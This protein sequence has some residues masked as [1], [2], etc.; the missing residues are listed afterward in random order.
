MTVKYFQEMYY[1]F[2]TTRAGEPSR[3]GWGVPWFMSPDG[4]D[5]IGKPV[6]DYY[7]LEKHSY[8]STETITV[9]RDGDMIWGVG[10]VDWSGYSKDNPKSSIN[11]DTMQAARNAVSF[12][13][14]GYHKELWFLAQ[15]TW[16]FYKTYSP[17][18]GEQHFLSWAGSTE[19][20]VSKGTGPWYQAIHEMFE[21][22][23]KEGI[24]GEIY[25]EL[26]KA[27][28]HKDIF[29]DQAKSR[30]REVQWNVIY[31]K[32]PGVAGETAH[33]Q[34]RTL[35]NNRNT[36]FFGLRGSRS[37][38]PDRIGEE[39]RW[40]A[41]DWNAMTAIHTYAQI[42]GEVD[43]RLGVDA[44]NTLFDQSSWNSGAPAE[45]EAYTEKTI[46]L[47]LENNP[48]TQI[49]APPKNLQDLEKL[50]REIYK[51]A[52]VIATQ[53]G[54]YIARSK[55]GHTGDDVV[56]YA[57]FGSLSTQW[58]E[59]DPLFRTRAGTPWLW[60]EKSPYIRYRNDDGTVTD[61]VGDYSLFY[62]GYASY[63]T[64]GKSINRKN[65]ETDLSN[66]NSKTTWAIDTRKIDADTLRWTFQD[67][68]KAKNYEGKRPFV[69]MGKLG[70]AAVNGQRPQ[71]ERPTVNIPKNDNEWKKLIS[72]DYF[73][74]K[75]SVV[76]AKKS[77]KLAKDSELVFSK[78]DPGDWDRMGSYDGLQKWANGIKWEEEYAAD[79]KDNVAQAD[80][81]SI[82]W[83]LGSIDEEG[84]P[85]GLLK[86]IYNNFL[87]K[88]G[89]EAEKKRNNITTDVKTAVEVYEEATS[90][91]A[92]SCAL[93]ILSTWHDQLVFKLF[94]E[95]AYAIALGEDDDVTK[96]DIEGF[97]ENVESELDASA[98]SAG[99]QAG[100]AAEKLTED[101]IEKRQVF[102]KQ[103]FLLSNM[104]GLSKEYRK[105]LIEKIDPGYQSPFG[106]ANIHT[107][108]NEYD[109]RMRLLDVEE[110]Q[111]E[112]TSD[113]MNY[114]LSPKG[115]DVDPFFDIRPE[116]LSAMVP[117]IRLF[118]VS[119]TKNG[120]LE[121]IEFDFP[122]SMND[123]DSQYLGNIQGAANRYDFGIKEFSF[124]FEGTSPAT[125]RN[126][127]TADLSL[128]FRD[129]NDL[130]KKRPFGEFIKS[131]RVGD[132][133][134][135]DTIDSISTKKEFSYLDLILFPGSTHQSNDEPFNQDA[136][137]YRIRADV[138]WVIREDDA[139]DKMAKTSGTSAAK[140]KTALE[141]INKSFY[142]NMVD[143]DLDFNTDGSVTIKINY[144]AYLETATKSTSMDV[145]A[146]PEINS[147]RNNLQEELNIMWDKCSPEQMQELINTYRT[148]E[149]ELLK[150]SYQSIVGRLVQRQRLFYVFSD[151]ESR[152]EFAEH[153][154][155]SEKPK[156]YNGSYQQ[157]SQDSGAS[158]ID[159]SKIDEAVAF[160]GDVPFG[161][162]LSTDTFSLLDGELKSFSPESVTN[163]DNE[164]DLEIVNFFYVGDLFHTLMDCMYL[165]PNK[166]EKAIVGKKKAEVKNTQLLISCFKITDTLAKPQKSYN[167]NIS[168]IPVALD[169]F[170]EW[171]TKNVIEGERRTYALMHFMRD[172]C[173]H[174]ITELLNEICIRSIEN[175]NPVRFQTST[176]L[177]ANSLNTSPVNELKRF[178]ERPFRN[179]TE[180]YRSGKLPFVTSLNNSSIENSSNY[181]IIYP[182][183]TKNISKGKTGNPV[184]D[185]ENGIRHLYIGRDRGLVK[186]ISFSKTDI[187]YLRESRYLTK[188]YN[189]LAQLANVYKAT[190]EMVGNTMFYP[191]MYVF[192]DPVSLAGEGMDCRDRDSIANALGLGG[193]HQVLKV[194][195]SIAGGKF[196]TT[197]E[198]QFE[199]AGDGSNSETQNPTQKT[200][201]QET[202]PDAEELKE[203]EVKAASNDT[204]AC[205]SIIEIRQAQAGDIFNPIYQNYTA[206]GETAESLEKRIETQ[207]IEQQSSIEQERTAIQQQQSE[208]AFIKLKEEM[209][210]EQ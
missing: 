202:D 37:P 23:Q 178:T 100:A 69:W 70:G 155:F 185:G 147:L 14:K 184:E 38:R 66:A 162:N 84:N 182:V 148:L 113:I 26:G 27:P 8:S 179:T 143:H 111:V 118:R 73:D 163:K 190:I 200:G 7:G 11:K 60:F 188:G 201:N 74:D 85:T 87:K 18:T 191:G 145:L 112:E 59:Y 134:Q 40:T 16:G 150:K 32:I 158:S 55:K 166:G 124:A 96:D 133:Q 31:D 175:N 128:F 10:F 154:F 165:A 181:I 187:K 195:S 64:N 42:T 174:L 39:E 194:K 67:G 56:Q 208:E 144:R 1:R 21:Q 72:E 151:Q 192:I 139:F 91:G 127:I 164:N 76:P 83:D 114:L 101:E 135:E 90:Y 43:N 160:L 183:S 54:M 81:Y 130:I 22:F 65:Q 203:I 2:L 152:S 131:P 137:N 210:S 89:E 142:L 172:F 79:A 149:D 12:A 53:Q 205:E 193:Y 58:E 115:K 80:S 99:N 50:K 77:Y 106:A 28:W 25:K 13:E 121:E 44:I 46:A 68:I 47:S 35:Y 20:E 129:F 51:K 107:P 104:E 110:S 117:Q 9:R 97:V 119:T 5:Q 132:V 62:M 93:T 146:S 102:Y 125:A 161:T 157:Y 189:G 141:K 120:R 122:K 136:S 82:S 57:N 177:A 75:K 45:F 116:L 156:M 103:C 168:E 49:T 24:W 4:D 209:E 92:Y 159:Q 61:A 30:D 52:R 3:V 170:I 197:I 196:N 98:D 6:D 204:K 88:F 173:N 94:D 63:G 71:H 206:P 48:F 153:G 36:Y 169:Y 171:F 140:L 186:T 167:V 123:D 78:I 180:G 109:G 207:Q 86:V 199:Y 105:E 15:I 29:G 41:A 33:D 176:V 17:F 198:A 108:N 126:D 19:D 95:I 34:A 138:G